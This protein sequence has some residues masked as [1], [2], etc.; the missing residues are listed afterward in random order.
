MPRR[1]VR[2]EFKIEAVRLAM[3]RGVSVPR[4]S[5]DATLLA[6]IDWS[7]PPATG[8]K[9]LSASDLAALRSGRPAGSTGSSG[10][11]A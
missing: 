3:E 4:A 8:P 5:R 1:T 11:C 10:R 2:R 9:A 6:A 7:L